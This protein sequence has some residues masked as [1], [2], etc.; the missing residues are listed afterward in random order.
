M[1]TD[2]YG[3]GEDYATPADLV[4]SD[5]SGYTYSGTPD[6]SLNTTVSSPDNYTY[7]TPA[8]LAANVQYGQS[9]N[10][11]NS[12]IGY[13]TPAELA[14]NVQYGQSPNAV[15]SGLGA[16][17]SSGLSN[18]IANLKAA[19]SSA[20]QTAAS[21]TSTVGGLGQL[22]T[23]LAA[24]YGALNPSFKTPQSTGGYDKAVPH[25]TAMRTQLA[26]A[27]Y[28]AYSGSSQPVMGRNFFTPTAYAAEGG[29]MGMAA[30]GH[31]Q[32]PHYLAGPTDGMADKLNTS[33]DGTQPAK[34]SHGEFVIPADVVS[35]LGNGNSTAGA[36]V[37]YKM[38]ERVRKARTGNPK[39]GKEI[40]PHKFTPGGIT[41]YAEGGPIAFDGTTGSAVVNPVTSLTP[42]GASNSSTLSSWAGPYVTDMLGKGQALANAP[43]PVYQGPLTAGTSPL[44]QQAFGTAANL[45][46]TYG[47]TQFQS[48]LGPVGSVQSYMNPYMQG[49]VN[50]QND[51]ARRQA[52]ISRVAG[53]ARL[54]QAG[55][56]GGGRQAIMESEGN[57]N[58]ATLQNQNQA[59][60]MNTAYNNAVNQQQA[61]AQMNMT[62]QQNTE[63]SKQF[64]AGYGLSSLGAQETA[65]AQQRGI[66]QQGI[67]ALHAQFEEQKAD[68]YKQVQFQQSLLSGLPISTSTT[69]PNT[70]SAGNFQDLLTNLGSIFGSTPDKVPA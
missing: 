13:A 24:I 49:A 11:T 61:A 14:A 21:K 15:Q 36:D 35:H 40:D 50:V 51:E 19:G 27:P 57:R 69:T 37:L 41:G 23:S 45:P 53:N 46:T 30:G 2:Y 38:M 58:L 34:L 66:E 28:Q 32:A 64:G 22:A 20:L 33:I 55:G 5:Y 26:Q 56:Y 7:A 65:G 18:I 59:V 52:D 31:A 3:L 8:E 43:A 6:Y 60:G 47:A 4:N 10:A 39:Q 62:G 9:P 68:P 54:T 29:L 48:A 1:A 70:S 67:D 12:G 63:A 25:L 42:Q 44:Q 16:A 17:G